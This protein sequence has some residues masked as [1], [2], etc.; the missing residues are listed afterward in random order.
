MRAAVRDVIAF[1]REEKDQE[2]IDAQAA[3]REAGGEIVQLTAS[4]RQQFIDAV[5]PIYAQMKDQYSRR[6]QQLLGI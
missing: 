4:E 2:E 6:I 5:E 3:I 1:Q